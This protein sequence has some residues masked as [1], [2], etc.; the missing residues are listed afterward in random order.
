MKTRVLI[1]FGLASLVVLFGSFM[2]REKE[3]ALKPTVDYYLLQDR[4]F[5]TFI[6]NLQ[7]MEALVYIPKGKIS[8]TRSLGIS[9]LSG[10]K[11]AALNKQ[12]AGSVKDWAQV[13]PSDKADE[14]VTLDFGKLDMVCYVNQGSG[15]EDRLAEQLLIKWDAGTAFHKVESVSID[16]SRPEELLIKWEGSRTWQAYVPVT[17]R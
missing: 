1:T 11:A 7:K 13:F 10:D 17:L 3:E 16:A 5:T 14:A 2:V 9:A 8:D 12:V 15:G 4:A 6:G